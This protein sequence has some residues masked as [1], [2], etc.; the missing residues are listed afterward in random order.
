[1]PGPSGPGEIQGLKSRT[2][3]PD[4]VLKLRPARGLYENF[5]VG[6]D[7]LAGLVR[8]RQGNDDP[9]PVELE[10]VDDGVDPCDFF[11]GEHLDELYHPRGESS[12]LMRKPG[13]QERPS[14]CRPLG[15]KNPLHLQRR[16]GEAHAGVR[17]PRR[18]SGRR[19]PSRSSARPRSC[20]P[21]PRA[22]GACS[23]PSLLGFLVSSCSIGR[24]PQYSPAASTYLSG[25]EDAK[26]R[27]RRRFI[28]DPRALRLEAVGA[29]RRS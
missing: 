4:P 8:A 20:P 2:Q 7:A 11:R 27:R 18:S 3:I 23:V 17:C 14:R 19:L 22:P 26:G 24:N 12:G 1:M 29:R 6:E 21:D 16:L 10:L 9:V 5:P 13:N 15:G 28:L 25:F